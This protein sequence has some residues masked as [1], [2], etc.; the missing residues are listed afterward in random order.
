MKKLVIV[1]NGRGGS[2]KD[3]FCEAIGTEWRVINVSSITPIKE[4]AALIGWDGCKDDRG[5]LLLARLKEAMTDYNDLPL[6]YLLDEYKA[7]LTSD[8]LVMFVHIREQREIER[9]L[10]C[11]KLPSRTLLVRKPEQDC[12]TYGN[13]ADDLADTFSYDYSYNNTC[14]L[15]EMPADAVR[16]FRELLA[17]EGIAE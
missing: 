8:A 17:K 4:L 3:T 7:F 1:I 13:S 14:P 5:R 2:G 12:L 11:V 15:D 16:F 9:F 10:D 6:R